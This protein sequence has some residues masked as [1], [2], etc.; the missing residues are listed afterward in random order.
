MVTRHDTA[1]LAA[2]RRRL[3]DAIRHL[4][5]LLRLLAEQPVKPRTLRGHLGRRRLAYRPPA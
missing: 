1:T 3:R 5:A 2:L 4:A